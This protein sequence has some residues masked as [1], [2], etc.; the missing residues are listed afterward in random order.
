MKK[1]LSSG[2]AEFVFFKDLWNFFQEFYDPEDSDVYWDSVYEAHKS[3]GEKYKDYPMCR[4]GAKGNITKI[5]Q[6]LLIEKGYKLQ[7]YGADGSFGDETEK[8]I[9]RDITQ[10]DKVRGAAE[11]SMYEDI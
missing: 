3:L 5:I 4:K 11:K 9:T 10:N 8:A 1:K 2:D 6:R 7:L